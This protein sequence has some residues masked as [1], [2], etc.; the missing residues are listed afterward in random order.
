M[1][2][3]EAVKRRQGLWTR[4]GFTPLRFRDAATPV[5]RDAVTPT[6]HDAAM[7]RARGDGGP[8]K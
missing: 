3:G 4:L 1:K 6:H 2:R 7:R 8:R 5:H